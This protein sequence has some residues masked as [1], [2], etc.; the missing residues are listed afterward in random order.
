MSCGSDRKVKL[1]NPKTGLLLKTYAGHGDEVCD[2]VS[3]CDSS[4][5][6]TGSNDKSIIYWDVSTGLPVRRLRSHAGAV[7]VVRFNEDSS[8]AL[9]GSR[10]NT[11]MC[12]DIRTRGLEPIQT[13]REAKDCIT[14]IIVTPT[15]IVTSSLDGCVRQYDIRAGELTCD[16]IG[17]PI[18]AVCLTGDEQCLLASC[19]DDVIRLLD[20]DGGEILSEY[21][22]HI[23]KE[24]KIECALLKGD[25]HVIS[26]SSNG[27][28]ILWDFLEA[29]EVK[30]F[31]IA[32]DFSTVIHSLSTHPS[33][34]D[35]LFAKKR[36]IQLWGPSDVEIMEEDC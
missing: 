13:L 18:T 15:K 26:G 4:F 3:S 6:V 27:C 2:V 22:G 5:I 1:W 20:L 8:V 12:W 23:C 35:V 9:S 21:S 32:K 10:D 36:E 31:N 14:G 16:K 7:S 29:K 33:N 34:E 28:A 19:S 17:E 30:R 24:Y 11:V 25:S